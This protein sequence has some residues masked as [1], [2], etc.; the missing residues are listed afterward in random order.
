MKVQ[1]ADGYILTSDTVQ[2]ELHVGANTT[3]YFRSLE[4]A[5]NRSIELIR[6]D[7]T[8]AFTGDVERYLTEINKANNEIFGMVLKNLNERGV[9]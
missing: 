7:K 2:Y 6:K 3:F 4:D 1:L 5:L 8:S 9:L